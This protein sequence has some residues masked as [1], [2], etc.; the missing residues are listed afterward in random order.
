MATG[1]QSY[2]PSA[3]I[4]VAAYRQFFMASNNNPPMASGS[5]S[6]PRSAHFRARAGQSAGLAAGMFHVSSCSG[7]LLS[8]R[9]GGFPACSGWRVD[10]TEKLLP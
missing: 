2:W 10:G 3:G 4:F 1:G 8:A 9:P 7:A 6:H 5:G